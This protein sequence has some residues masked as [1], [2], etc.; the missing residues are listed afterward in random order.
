MKVL[1]LEP[2]YGGSHRAFIDTF[3]RHT[4]HD[5][6]LLTLPARKWKWRMRG[7]AL[8]FAEQLAGNAVRPDVIFTCDMLSVADLR[9]L[10]PAG[11]QTIPVVC[12]FHENQ[13]TYPLSDHDFR[14]FQ[15]GMTN[16]TS[17][18]A[19]DRVW[20]NS[21]CHREAF[22]E[23]ASTLLAKM[24]DHI[25]GNLIPRIRRR[26]DVHYPPVEPRTSQRQPTAAEA[27]DHPPAILWPHR[28]EYDKNPQPFFDA[29]LW[30]KEKG[31]P[32]RLIILG[33]QFRT[34]PTVFADACRSL[35]SHVWHEGFVEDH[36]AYLE[37]VGRADFVVST[38]I[39][40][41]FGIAVVE[42][43][44]AGAYPILP[45]RLSYPELLPSAVHGEILYPDSA[46]LG[47]WIA[48]CLQKSEANRRDTLGLI[49]AW[50]ADLCHPDVAV[51]GMDDG[52]LQLL[53]G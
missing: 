35:Q 6:V 25:P 8:W 10:L 38:A 41:N 49:Q 44:L 48:N 20:F 50:L 36:A 43:M 46:V 39:Q 21:N 34:A 18:L 22:L 45:G 37:W 30:M 14:D 23:A 24:P 7:A 29:L 2:Y 16:I 13:L 53:Q 12:Y 42:A 19:S 11:W 26:S 3:L 4:K 17:C 32:F 27:P 5:C 28:W 33:E 52:L 51:G 9:A 47:E 31:V 1:I 40:E 15:Y